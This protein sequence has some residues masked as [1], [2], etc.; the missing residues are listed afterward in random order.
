M[1]NV[2]YGL[3]IITM[4]LFLGLG[5][6]QSP[7]LANTENEIEA[8]EEVLLNITTVNKNQYS[9][10][11]SIV[12][13]KHNV[14]YLSENESE[15]YKFKYNEDIINNIS[16][17]DLFIY[18]GINN[19]PWVNDF[20][21]E[22]KKGDLGIINMSRG[23]KTLTYEN[24]DENPYYWLGIN[25]YK[26]ALYNV[27]SAIQEKDPKN[28]SYYE[29][30][31]TNVI[32]KI[33]ESA[34]EVKLELEKYKDYTILTNTNTFDYLLKDLGLTSVNVKKEVTRKILEEKKLDENKII[35]VKEKDPIEI[36]NI[37][38]TKKEDG[39]VEETK[40]TNEEKL[41]VPEVEVK[42]P[43]DVK[44]VE[45]IRWDGEKTLVELALSNIKLVTDT[46]KKLPIVTK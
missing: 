5:F 28:K 4:I 37:I 7:L 26:I 13:N 20:I 30:N 12:L 43:L 6:F 2:T 10:V 25:E 32:N 17:R 41:E 35:F 42:K 14:E 8:G 16:G 21:A 27:K 40:K 24:G 44:S 46:L 3:I 22:L 1:K 34:K 38:E 29:E 39:K 19:E 45:L 15:I 18:S 33:E 36:V 11:K 9:M 31:Y 23:I